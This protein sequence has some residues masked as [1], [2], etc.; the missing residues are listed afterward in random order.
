MDYK[1]KGNMTEEHKKNLETLRKEYEKSLLNLK[2]E[3]DRAQ[4]RVKKANAE[5]VSAEK[6]LADKQ[7]H[8]AECVARAKKSMDDV[9]SAKNELATVRAEIEAQKNAVIDAKGEADRMI[10]KATAEIAARLKACTQEEERVAAFKKETNSRIEKYERDSATLKDRIEK[11]RLKEENLAKV[12]GELM[13]LRQRILN[14]ANSANKDKMEAIKTMEKAQAVSKQAES[15]I[16]TSEERAIANDRKLKDL[17]AM[18][19]QQKDKKID[20]DYREMEIE[21]LRAKVNKLI[22][23]NNIK[24]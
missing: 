11:A 15:M 14:D 22:E 10:A 4:G 20:L 6:D 5:A 24:V 21:R 9:A 17:T 23:L 8:V 12:E 19:K 3:E 7:K 16:R 2:G 18:E 13:S 1:I